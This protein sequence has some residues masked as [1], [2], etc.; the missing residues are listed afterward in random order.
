MTECQNETMQEQLPLLARGTLS[1]SDAAT[2]RTHVA[3]CEACA[4]D[5]R[6][7]ERSARL[8]DQVTPRVDTAAILAKLPAAPGSRPVLTVS[9]GARRRF[10]PPRYALAAAASLVLVATL[11]LAALRDN[12]FGSAVQPDSLTDS[13]PT[14]VAALPVGLVGGNELGELGVDDL[15][16]L[17][18]ELDQLQATV[19]A[20]PVTMQRP[21]S[22]A[23][24]GL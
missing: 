18:R 1:T 8:F 10:A 2:L 16:R 14:L 21:V 6:L 13:N 22:S 17:L 20:E 3:G 15:E 5:L 23:P 19:A 7:L 4:A 24:E 11:S 12:F 9:R